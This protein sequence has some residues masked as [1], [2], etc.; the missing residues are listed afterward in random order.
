MR[1]LHISHEL[2]SRVINERHQGIISD[3]LDRVIAVHWLDPDNA[4]LVDSIVTNRADYP[5]Q[6]SVEIREVAPQLAI[7]LSSVLP[8]G[9][10]HP[11]NL[12]SE[13]LPIVAESFGFRLSCYADKEAAWVY[14]GPWDGNVRFL[15]CAPG[16]SSVFVAGTFYSDLKKCELVWSFELQRYV[17]WFTEHLAS[18]VQASMPTQTRRDFIHAQ[19]RLLEELFPTGWFI[20]ATRGRLQHPAYVRWRQCQDLLAR[21]GRVQYPDDIEIINTLLS[22]WLDNVSLIQATRGSVDNQQLGKLANYGDEAV[23]RRL[24]VVIQEPSQF[25]DTLVE[26]SC[27]AWHVSRGHNVEA[28]EENGMPDLALKIPG[29]QLPIRA[30]CKRIRKVASYSRVKG[31]IEKANAQIKRAGQRCYGLVYIDVSDRCPDQTSFGNDELPNEIVKIQREVQS[32]L[33]ERYTSISGVILLWKDHI[34]LPM[35]DGS[36]K[37]FCLLR[38]KG[39]LIRHRSPKEPLPDD[40]EPIMLGY[41]CMLQIVPDSGT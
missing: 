36:G 23:Q 37:V 35:T 24:Q 5:D 2:L 16:I 32:C 11:E 8:A 25:F 39:A 19:K 13:L 6:N 29:W 18:A 3:G 21:N 15:G 12:V 34:I 22:A 4:I 28:T 20:G 7:R 1:Y 26:V 10:L 31:V 30:E 41:T 27:A 14:E 9:S 40:S 17:A 38:Y 33:Y